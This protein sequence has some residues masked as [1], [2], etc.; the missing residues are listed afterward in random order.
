MKSLKN[1]K[2]SFVIVPEKSYKI[3]RFNLSYLSFY[4]IIFFLISAV[5][6]VSVMIYNFQHLKNETRIITE[7]TIENQKLYAEHKMLKS[8]IEDISKNLEELRNIDSRI[9]MMIG[10]RTSDEIFSG[11][12]GPSDENI[13]EAFDLNKEQFQRLKAKD[14]YRSSV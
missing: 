11:V 10:L 9:R 12:G 1:K 7:L 2:I 5:A 6:A 3:H 13:D 8:E 14:N 4:I